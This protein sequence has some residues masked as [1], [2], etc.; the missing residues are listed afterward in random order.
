MKIEIKHRYLVFPVSTFSP[1][2][3]F[4]FYDEGEEVYY[5]NIKLNPTEPT[6]YAY[7]DMA[8]FMGRTI[9]IGTTPE[10]EIVYTESDTMDI[11]GLY[12]E[13]FRPQVHFTTKNGWQ[14]DPN[15]LVYA[16]GEYHMF[17]QHNPC[18]S[19]WNNMH[20]NHAKSTDLIHWTEVGIA[21]GPDKHGEA[22][23]GSAIVD[24]DDLLGLKTG[25]DDTVA[26]YYTHLLSISRTPP[27]D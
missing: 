5:L 11:T 20:W 13:T 14:N 7:V 19:K 3:R 9:E 16:N 1:Q 23:S 10:V 4:R 8:R 17:Y 22:F 27:T 18:E 12:G 6:F 15:G 24:K 2:I 26:L 25:E 21:L